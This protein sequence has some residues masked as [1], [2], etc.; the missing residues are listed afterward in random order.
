MKRINGEAL[1]KKI[2]AELTTEV[3]FLKKGRRAPCVAF[4]R[5]GED[6]ASVS[7]VN[8]KQNTAAAIGIKSRL[9]IFPEKVS[10][11][12]LFAQIDDYNNDDDID[13][14]LVQAPLPKHISEIETFNKVSPAKDVDGFGVVNLGKLCQEDEE[15]FISCTPAGIIEMIKQEGIDTEGKHVVIVGRSLIVGKPSALLFL[16]KKIPGNATVTVCHSRT[17]DLSTHTKQADILISAIGL[18]NTITKEM[19]KPGV[20]VIDVGIN[21]VPDTSKKSGFRLVGDVHFESVAPL[22]SKITPV[23][24]GVGPMTVSMLMKNTV[25]AYRAKIKTV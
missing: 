11:E 21:R 10:R 15:G 18:P 23:P 2:I 24:G 13:G 7:Y 9:K 1:S 6:P 12:T 3:D 16:K 20:V 17:L 4:I 19:V 25:K 22:A 8:K 5:V 14:I